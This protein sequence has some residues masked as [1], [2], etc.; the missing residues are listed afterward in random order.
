[1]TWLLL[2]SYKAWSRVWTTLAFIVEKLEQASSLLILC[3][4][5]W[6]AVVQLQGSAQAK[7]VDILATIDE[8]LENASIL[9]K[10]DSQE[11]PDEAT[12]SQGQLTQ[13]CKEVGH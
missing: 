6:C 11:E 10:L 1:M 12:D 8:K 13:D 5:S 4:H 3:S 7:G 9:A 2:R